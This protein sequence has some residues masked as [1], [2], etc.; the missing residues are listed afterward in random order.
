M[1]A[2]VLSLG[3]NRLYRIDYYRDKNGKSEF[4]E[5]LIDLSK[6]A[7]T[8]KDAR[9]K[10]GIIQRYIDFLQRC[11]LQHLPSDYCK[12]IEKDIWE[13]RPD[14]HRILFFYYKD[15]TYVL[16][17]HF[18]KK[19]KKTPKREIIKAIKEKDEYVKKN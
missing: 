7:L 17:H 10:F 15:D 12:H 1:N 19:T 3:G 4:E 16:L 9:I 2:Y 5:Y 13:L 8:S 11:G 6:K 18:I 14:K